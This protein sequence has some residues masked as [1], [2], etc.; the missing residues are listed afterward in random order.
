[1]LSIV[2]TVISVAKREKLCAIALLAGIPSLI[3]VVK[4]CVEI[5]KAV[6]GAR[7]S[8]ESFIAYQKREQAKEARVQNYCAQ[9]RTNSSLITSDDF[10]NGQTNQDWSAQYGLD[11]LIEDQSFKFTPDVIDYLLKKFPKRTEELIQYKHL[12]RDELIKIIKDTQYSQRVRQTAMEALVS[13][14]SFELTDKWKRCVFEQFPNVIGNLLY[15]ERLTKAE[16]EA[17]IADP[18][19]SDGIKELAKRNLKEGRYKN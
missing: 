14:R 10:W 18:A 3:F 12:N 1:M 17:L 5:P 2:A 4:V 6:E 8:N 13:D 16:I 19:I 7:K 11:R 9:F 15:D